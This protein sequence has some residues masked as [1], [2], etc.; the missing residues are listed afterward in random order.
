M[1]EPRPHAQQPTGTFVRRSLQTDLAGLQQRSS[2]C[3]QEGDGLSY[4]AGVFV[5]KLIDESGPAKMRR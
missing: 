4:Q 3:G 2:S 1:V 5:S